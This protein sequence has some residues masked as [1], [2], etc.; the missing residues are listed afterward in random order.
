MNQQ[1]CEVKTNTI[2]EPQ[3]LSNCKE[4]L[5]FELNNKVRF[6]DKL[7][8]VFGDKLTISLVMR[9]IKYVDIMCNLL[10]MSSISK[11]YLSVDDILKEVNSPTNIV[12]YVEELNL[13][14][15]F[16]NM[17]HFNRFR[18][19]FGTESLNN[20]ALLLYQIVLSSVRQ[21]VIFS[22]KGNQNDID[23]IKKFTKEYFKAELISTK[24]E[25]NEE[26][27]PI[28]PLV[29]NYDEVMRSV[30][31][32]Y[33]YIAKIDIFLSQCIIPLLE[34]S[35][36]NKSYS[37]RM[38]YFDEMIHKNFVSY[39]Y[40]H[41]TD[42]PK[43][44]IENPQICSMKIIEKPTK[45]DIAINWITLNYPVERE[46]RIDYWNKYIR[47]LTDTNDVDTIQHFTQYVKE[48]TGAKEHTYKK[49]RCW[50]YKKKRNEVV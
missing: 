24:K 29:K 36:N 18:Q 19:R 23:N 1:I 4:I 3:I 33:D 9:S 32:L 49:M 12:I 35:S 48:I 44:K 20:I 7:N 6:L 41:T 39:D 10:D 46:F 2:Q 42:F 43:L 38:L 27:I 17:D 15:F 11:I 28:I 25:N 34:Y 37:R 21:K 26:I 31:G 45:K 14:V 47:S 30:R 5:N 16:D 13:Y 22:V 40:V 50:S 8:E